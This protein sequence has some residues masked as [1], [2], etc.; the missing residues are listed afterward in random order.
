MH[1]TNPIFVFSNFFIIKKCTNDPKAI[2]RQPVGDPDLIL[3]LS[4]IR[5]G[6]AGKQMGSLEGGEC[7]Q[8]G[9]E[10]GG[11]NDGGFL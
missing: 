11:T 5:R 7:K 8:S 4:A 2:N 10:K 3:N 9:R 1:E 6:E